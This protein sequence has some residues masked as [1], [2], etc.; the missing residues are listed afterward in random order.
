[1]RWN[2]CFT[3][4]PVSLSE[5]ESLSCLHVAPLLLCLSIIGHLLQSWMFG[6]TLKTM[7]RSPCWQTPNVGEKHH[8]PPKCY[9]RLN[10]KSGVADISSLQTLVFN[11]LFSF[12]RTMTVAFVR[13]FSRQQQAWLS[14]PTV[15]RTFKARPWWCWVCLDPAKTFNHADWW[16]AFSWLKASLSTS[17]LPAAHQPS[18]PSIKPLIVLRY[19]WPVERLFL[20]PAVSH[21]PSGLTL[22]EPAGPKWHL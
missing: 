7:E 11:L 9:F 19:T 13:L 17:S 12:L 22:H 15:S 10:N 5:V 6:S 18:D 21:T 3:A 2:R 1:M 8:F 20:Y 16:G 4:V 14:P